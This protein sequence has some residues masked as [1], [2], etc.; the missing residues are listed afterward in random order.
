[1]FPCHLLLVVFIALV[2]INTG[3]TKYSKATHSHT[4]SLTHTYA[5][6]H[7]RTHTHTQTKA[8][9]VKDMAPAP[10]QYYK[11]AEWGTGYKRPDN[12]KTVFISQVSTFLFFKL[13]P[14]P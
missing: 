12:A 1:M 3:S 6:A 13:N 14:E 7:A 10:G 5:R 8:E 11:S 4:L 9:A 2:F